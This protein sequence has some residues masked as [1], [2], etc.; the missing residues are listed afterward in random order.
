MNKE[1]FRQYV[2]SILLEVKKEKDDGDKKDPK[3]KNY[4]DSTQ[5][6]YKKDVE[7]DFNETSA[8]LVKQIER[9]VKTIDKSASVVLDDHNDITAIL[10]GEFRIRINPVGASLFN[11][12]AFRNM[13]DRVYAI[14]LSKEQV[15]D[16]VKV[17]FV[18]RKK[19]YVQSAYDKSM[20]NMKD[21]SDKKS[22]ELPKGNPVKAIQV[23][24][25]NKEDAVTDKKDL[26]NAP[27]SPAEDPKRQED[28]DV[29]KAK[30]MAKAQKMSKKVVDDTLV[31]GKKDFGDTSKIGKKV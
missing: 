9:L 27:M 29:E 8:K 19:G 15:I 20:D 28:H 31:I 25:K 23:S 6:K 24:D 14:A 30:N 22:K 10:P 12:E 11:V 1:Q 5:S 18:A 4:L 13:S 7:G 21:A 17:N 16:F 3:A 2:K 26:P